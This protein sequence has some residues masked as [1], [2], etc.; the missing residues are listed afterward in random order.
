M[1]LALQK[2]CEHTRIHDGQQARAH[3]VSSG[4]G[5]GKLAA[6]TKGSVV[7]PYNRFVLPPCDPT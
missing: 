5:R 4:Y 2:P 3:R 1:G 6:R 7:A